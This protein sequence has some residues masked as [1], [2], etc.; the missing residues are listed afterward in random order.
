MANSLGAI[1][2]MAPFSGWALSYGAD[3]F[4]VAENELS[5]C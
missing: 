4:Q 3:N 5:S 1:L 2:I